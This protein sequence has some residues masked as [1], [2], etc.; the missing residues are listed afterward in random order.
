MPIL[1]WFLIEE[2]RYLKKQF[3]VSVGLDSAANN[4]QT[5]ALTNKHLPVQSQ[6]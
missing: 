1:I 3:K 4:D 6:E 2:L 5:M